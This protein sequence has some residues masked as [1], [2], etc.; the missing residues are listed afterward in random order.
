MVYTRGVTD[1]NYNV[2]LFAI[3]I[4][5]ANASH[6][7]RL[8]Y[9]MLILTAG[10]YKQT[11]HSYLIAAGIN[12]VVS[13]ALVYFYGLLGVA[14]GTLVSMTYQTIWMAWYSYKNIVKKGMRRFR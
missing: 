2:P 14:I 1:A 4:T 11:Q 8:P 13:I 6:S 9:S 7:F 10:H 3:L 5:L 12:I